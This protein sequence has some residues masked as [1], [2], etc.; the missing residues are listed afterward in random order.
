[1]D[2]MGEPRPDV[3]VMNSC[4]WDVSRWVAGGKEGEGRDGGEGGG[5]GREESHGQ[6]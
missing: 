6:T 1:M 5:E 4:L 3:I 2:L